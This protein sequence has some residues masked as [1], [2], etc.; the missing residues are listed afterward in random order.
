MPR[1]RSF[2]IALACA[3]ATLAACANEFERRVDRRLDAYIGTTEATVV[4]A[5]GQPTSRAVLPDGE[6]SM[7]FAVSRNVVI[8]G[9]YTTVPQRETVDGTFYGYG[10]R[11]QNYTETRTTYVNGPWL[12][13][14]DM[15]MSCLITFRID[16]AG[17][18]V[19]YSYL[20]KDYSVTGN[21][22]QCS[23]VLED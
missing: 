4:M 20:D 5:F 12:P 21:G 10:G 19:S 13:S 2:L 3:S 16:R 1:L 14:S 23:K 7:T 17:Q 22:Y 9:F 15:A 8:G 18:I 11:T 6:R